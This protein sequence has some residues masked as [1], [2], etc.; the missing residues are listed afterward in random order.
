MNIFFTTQKYIE[1]VAQDNQITSE[2]E[3][4]QILVKK[5]IFNYINE[6]KPEEMLTK[7]LIMGKNLDFFKKEKAQNKSHEIYTIGYL[8]KRSKGKV[9][10]FQRRWFI[11]IS[12]K[13]LVI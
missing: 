4:K 12:A 5:G 2:I 8:L 10:Y 6:I 7:R 3:N 1:T 13:P 11:L 9:K